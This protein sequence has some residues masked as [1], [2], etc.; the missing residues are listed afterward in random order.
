MRQRK[1]RVADSRWSVGDSLGPVRVKKGWVSGGAWNVIANG[2]Q[3]TFS[4]ALCRPQTTKPFLEWMSLEQ[5]LSLWLFE[6]WLTWCSQ[7]KS[8]NISRAP[9]DV[10]PGSLQS[11][12]ACHA[13]WCGRD[14]MF[15]T[16]FQWHSVIEWRWNCGHP[17]LWCAQKVATCDGSSRIWP[18]SQCSSG[19]GGIHEWIEM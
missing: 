9:W 8:C 1:P 17:A 11:R 4:W 3:A 18:S 19:C 15:A 10:K 5:A 6:S 7:T 16:R 2:L 13:H 14:S 12:H